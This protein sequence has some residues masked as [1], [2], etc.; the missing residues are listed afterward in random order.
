MEKFYYVIQTKTV[1]LKGKVVSKVTS[2]L[3]YNMNEMDK[4]NVF[5]CF[6]GSVG[7][8]SSSKQY[9]D[10]GADIVISNGYGMHVTRFKSDNEAYKGLIAKPREFNDA[11]SVINKYGFDVVEKGV[12]GKKVKVVSYQQAV[13]L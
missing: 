9:R 1:T 3:G 6:D 10:N 4:D 13:E 5:Y 8:K 2:L 12:A 7:H 11:L